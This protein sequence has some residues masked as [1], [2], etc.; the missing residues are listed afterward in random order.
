MIH[1]LRISV[2][3]VSTVAWLLASPRLSAQLLAFNQ[4]TVPRPE[5]QPQSGKV[6]LRE[7]LMQYKK[8]YGIDILFEEKLL[9]GISISTAQLTGNA[10][11]E[12]NLTQLLR[13]LGLR[14]KRVNKDTFVIVSTKTLPKAAP[15][16]TPSPA[17]ST[18]SPV[19][20][21][22]NLTAQ[23]VT[24]GNFLPNGQNL[25]KVVT[26][27]VMSESGERLP[28][29]NVVI[30]GTQR[31]TAT[32]ENGNFRVEVADDNTVLIFSFIGYV[33][34][35]ILVGTRTIVS[36]SLK[37][38]DM[39]LNEVVVV[40]YG[41]IKKTDLTGAV[42]SVQT[43]D[44]VRANPVVAARAIQGQV[45]GAT[46]TKSSNKPGAGYSITIRGE[47]TINNSTEPLVVIDGLMGG[48]LNNLNP[49]DIQSMDVLKD[50]SSTA[51]YG[52]RGANGVII[53]TTKK[54]LSGKP[55]VSY[56]SYVGIKTPAHVPRLMNTEEFYK[57]T[58]TDRVLEGATG[59]TF[60]AAETANI[61]AGK[62][63]DW[64]D[65]ITAPGIQMSHNISVSGGTEKTTYRFSGGFLNEDGNVLYTGFKRYNLNAGLDS[66][67]GERFKV[68]FTTYLTYSDQNV[69]SGE[70]LR[71]AYRARPTGTVYYSDLANPS[72]NGDLNIDGYAFWMGINDKQVG[73]PLLDID[74][75]TSKLQT[76]TMNA[77][78]NA[79]G[80]VTLL[81]GLTFRSSLSA[82]Y[83]S[84][85]LG[86]FRGQWSKSQI[87]AKPR[88][89]Y[90]N[91]TIGNY[92][93]D[94]I[95]NYTLDFGKHKIT[96]TALQSAFYQRNEAY[97]I[98][99]RD[100][101]Y[102]SDWYAL[103]TAATIS[104]IN[105]SLVERSILSY[106]GR[107][108]YSFNDKYLL[109][110][111]GRS[112]GASQLAEGNKWAFFPSVAFAWRLGDE[113]FIN[114][115]N[116]FSNLK[117]RLSY[118]QVG[119][120][121]VN[122]YSTQAGLLNTGYDFDGTAAYGFAPLNLAN[123]DLRWERSKELNLGIDFGF[124]KNRIAASL[125]IYNRKTDDLI[126]NQKLPTT[127]GFT[128]VIA[129]VGKIENKGVEL[130][131]NTV[132]ISKQ[133][134]NWNTTFAFTR[135]Q[136]KLLELYGNGQMAD[137]GN[138][139]FVGYP[140]RANFDF[141]FDGIWQTADK[142]PAT[143]YK[144]VPGSVRVV[145]QNN[146]GQIS[147][148]DAIDDRVYLGTQL[149]NWILGITNRFKYKNVDFS[150]F[151]Y[152]R[153][154]VQYRNNTLA[155]TFGEIGSTRYNKLAGLDYWRSDN[156]SNTFFGTVAA[157][158]YRNAIF[159]Q[160]ASFLRISDIT[161]GYTLGSRALNKVK[162]SNAR[163]YLQVLNPFVFSN[164]TGF[165]PEFNSAIFQDDV[166]S[167]TYS[168]GVNISF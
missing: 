126:L 71:N 112:D 51:I 111:T 119:N 87:G 136:N 12:R 89:Q 85:R 35:E 158:P 10:N 50:A 91:R 61:N 116:V 147:S 135:N 102:A 88:A 167:A 166:P 42:A 28:G 168:F 98:S 32:D 103:N 76:T 156:P 160:D 141:Q 3:L 73:N 19:E 80:E 84:Q 1:S 40:G 14:L 9:E 74:P 144:Q 45:A 62:T 92:T 77:M 41:E 29:V 18:P 52:A 79:Y 44:I 165:D 94:N 57:V 95:L 27:A 124:F 82:S 106:M 56:D 75:K 101:P 11:A 17:A 113:P 123:K 24:P 4:Q 129:N 83:T 117:L 54:G 26:G 65:L 159:Y 68:G 81:K 2:F 78:A 20:R 114:N 143:K 148:T 23:A 155:G 133:N 60:T 130:T 150:F 72:E 121:T 97:S 34:Q 122:P 152:Y 69:G 142:D 31:G 33:K 55:R 118:G 138:N 139:L 63:T 107:I 146:D 161:L 22:T 127:T 157:N 153:N 49:N 58:F 37:A 67:L 53:I 16:E 109:T 110:L 8:Q 39:S 13:P 151:T 132:N 96:A 131:L 145:D 36:V 5:A 100:L 162:M 6:S 149:P 125:E 48:D 137:K 30:K 59:A 64:V 163:L 128:Q 99:V 154:G 105:S 108:N 164:F 66:K 90:D 47:N 7:A 93:I 25:A 140:I 120:S 38:D 134:F 21:P 70:S 104:G 115:L 43:K 46:V 15:P 86:D